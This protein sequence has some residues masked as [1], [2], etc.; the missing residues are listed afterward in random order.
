MC[1][2]L[3]PTIP[4]PT[5]TSPSRS[6]QGCAGHSAPRGE[7]QDPPILILGCGFCHSASPKTRELS[8][9]CIF[10]GELVLPLPAFFSYM[11]PKMLTA[12]STGGD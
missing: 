8:E 7:D 5:L 1:F 3:I 12:N 4:S 2:P 11:V 6:L 10:N 9:I